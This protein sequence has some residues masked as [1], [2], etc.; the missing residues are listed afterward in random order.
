MRKGGRCS[1]SGSRGGV[2]LCKL[3]DGAD[4]SVNWGLDRGK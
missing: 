3:L 4:G 2:G 1:S